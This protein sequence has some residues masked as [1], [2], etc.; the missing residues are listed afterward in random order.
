MKDYSSITELRKHIPD[1]GLFKIYNKIV[2]NE[3]ILNTLQY[4]RYNE[5]G[6]DEQKKIINPLYE[7]LSDDEKRLMNEFF[8]Y[9]KNPNSEL[10]LVLRSGKKDIKNGLEFIL[11]GIMK[12][13]DNVMGA[14]YAHFKDAKLAWGLFFI[15]VILSTTTGFLKD[16]DFGDGLINSF[17][18][19]LLPEISRA[20][21]YFYIA[22]I[23]LAIIYT[24]RGAS[25]RRD[26][27]GVR[28]YTT[29]LKRPVR[30]YSEKKLKR[31]IKRKA[32]K[33]Y[34]HVL[35]GDKFVLKETDLESNKVMIKRIRRM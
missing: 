19:F 9:R 13:S 25:S 10:E 8:S 30:S 16:H 34:K 7:I 32:K 31:K 2:T 15:N 6:L 27:T 24:W 17:A 5:K 22:L 11:S 23:P 33:L 21:M 35:R 28:D 14:Q 18:S 4:V 12:D 26:L 3:K 29:I 1:S 20:C